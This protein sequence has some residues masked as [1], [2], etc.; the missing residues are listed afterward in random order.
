MDP[1]AVPLEQLD[2]LWDFDDPAASE[3]RFAALLPRARTEGDG[4]FL[5]ETLT[6]L[7]RAQGLQRHFHDAWQTLAEAERALR[8]EDARGR[9]RLVLERGRVERF[10]KRAGLGRQAFLEAWELAFAVGEDGLAVDAAHMLGLVEAPDEARRW[11]ERAMELALSSKDPD[12]RRWVGSLANNMAWARHEEGDD[13]GAIALFELARDEWLADGREDRARIA[14]WSIARCMRSQGDVGAALAEHEALLAELEARGE[15]D[16]FVYEEIGECLLAL[17]KPNDAKPY[18]A[19]AYAEL[20][21][22]VRLEASHPGRLERLERLSR[23]AQ[24]EP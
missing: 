4:A 9:V 24:T 21:Q 1:R 6:Q 23:A 13:D 20:S 11:N 16:G 10:E 14:R 8:H 18:F 5:A 17:G 2:T 19:R 3:R 7:A 15:R 12:A 22:D